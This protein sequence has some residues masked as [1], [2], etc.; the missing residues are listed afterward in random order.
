MSKYEGLFANYAV[1][2]GTLDEA[3]SDFEAAY[4]KYEV[5]REVFDRLSPA[6][7][8]QLNES[9]RLSF[10]NQGI[11]CRLFGGGRWHRKGVPV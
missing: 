6:D 5:I 9:A 10:L 4:L 11:T 2:E 8:K 3:F 7:F 1:P